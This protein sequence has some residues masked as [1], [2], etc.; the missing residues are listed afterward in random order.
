MI[1]LIA[2]GICGAY[3]YSNPKYAYLVEQTCK[4][5]VPNYNHGL[6]RAVYK[7]CIDNTN[8]TLCNTTCVCDQDICVDTH[9]MSV[10]SPLIMS[11]FLI[12]IGV[13]CGIVAIIVCCRNGNGIKM[14]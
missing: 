2:A 8:I 1:F 5:L 12:V 14:F 3:V 10:N 6:R 7:N 11:I 4:D 9:A 13:I